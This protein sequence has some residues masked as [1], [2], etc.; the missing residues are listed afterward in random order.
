MDWSL[1]LDLT[2]HVIFCVRMCAGVSELSKPL[3][4]FFLLL[5]LCEAGAV[6]RSRLVVSAGRNRFPGMGTG[7]E[8][9]QLF[10]A[11]GVFVC[12]LAAERVD[13]LETDV[14]L[15]ERGSLERKSIRGLSRRNGDCSIQ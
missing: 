12:L 8:K 14:L 2:E 10:R 3:A 7:R 1:I 5:Y 4:P 13:L 9:E 6:D 15:R 11:A